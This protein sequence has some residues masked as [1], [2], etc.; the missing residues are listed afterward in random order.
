[1]LRYL[2]IDPFVVDLRQTNAVGNTGWL[3]YN[4]RDVCGEKKKTP[5]KNVVFNHNLLLIERALIS[6]YAF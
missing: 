5:G 4:A 2:F 3:R 1:M 6:C